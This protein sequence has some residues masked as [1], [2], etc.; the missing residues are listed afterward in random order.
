SITDWETGWPTDLLGLGLRRDVIECGVGD[1]PYFDVAV[2]KDMSFDDLLTALVDKRVLVEDYSGFSPISA[3]LD[4]SMDDLMDRLETLE[5]DP[6]NVVRRAASRWRERERV[7][8]PTG[9]PTIP[10][11]EALLQQKGITVCRKGYLETGYL[12]DDDDLP[13]GWVRVRPTG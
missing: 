1:N 2:R 9:I 4:P 5:V 3:I 7:E 13:P 10:R 12:V 8:P 6:E 11:I